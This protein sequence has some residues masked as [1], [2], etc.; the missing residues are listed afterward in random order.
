MVSNSS[1][2]V[3]KIDYKS[4]NCKNDMKKEKGGNNKEGNIDD[5][6]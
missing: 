1:N 4:D 5:S 6:T 3:E 2:P